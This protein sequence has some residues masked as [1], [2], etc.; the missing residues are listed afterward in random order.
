MPTLLLRFGRSQREQIVTLVG[1]AFG[2]AL[3]TAL[4]LMLR[5]PPEG[6]EDGGLLQL[7]YYGIYVVLPGTLLLQTW[8]RPRLGWSVPLALG[9][10]L[11]H[12]LEIL[13]YWSLTAMGAQHLY[14]WWPLAPVAFG[15]W[16]WRSG[17]ENH[18][19]P[20]RWRILPTQAGSFAAL[21]LCWGV[22]AATMVG[23]YFRGTALRDGVL[24][25]NTHHDWVYLISRLAEIRTHWPWQDP[26]MAGSALSYHYFLLVH[27]AAAGEVTGQTSATLLLRTGLVP[28][29]LVVLAQVYWLGRRFARGRIGGVVALGMFTLSGVG[30]TALGDGGISL[31][32]L[33]PWLFVSPTF[34]F[35][36]SFF[37]G[38]IILLYLMGSRPRLRW[39]DALLLLAFSIMATGA[40]GTTVPPL[41]LAVTGWS[42]WSWR[43]GRG[44]IGRVLLLGGTLTLGVGLIYALVLSGWGTAK[45]AWGLGASFQVTRFWQETYPGWAAYIGSH[46]PA[47]WAGRLTAFACLAATIFLLHGLR[48][49]GLVHLWQTQTQGNRGLGALL[50]WSVLGCF[51]FGWTLTMDSDGQLYFLLPWRLPLAVLAAGGV[52]VVAKSNLVASLRP[53]PRQHFGILASAA[54]VSVGLWLTVVGLPWWCGLIGGGA[55]LCWPKGSARDESAPAQSEPWTLARRVRVA[56]LVIVALVTLVLSA[57]Q[58]RY[59]REMNKTALLGWWLAEAKPTEH[60]DEMREAMSWVEANL[61][62]EAVLVCNGFTTVNLQAKPPVLVERT[63]LDKYY[64]YSAFAARRLWIEGPAD[65]TTRWSTA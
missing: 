9:A 7:A 19:Q 14:P 36:L 6:V 49:W 63:T 48:L 37:G 59:W 25:S 50:G 57:V 11:G 27:L 40:K 54:G 46:L 39:R 5:R 29:L 51:F 60:M 24:L 15:V 65:F 61:P 43:R 17:T 1:L 58:L 16:R 18:L 41:A 26:S 35:G 38:G 13:V 20:R 31:L 56:G 2:G 44:S 3:F 45:T 62:K 4:V 64:Y 22:F 8:S 12:T 21:M 28:L 30:W 53:V 42:V 10:P 23:F 52:M 33:D 34:L 55:V 47:P 32:L